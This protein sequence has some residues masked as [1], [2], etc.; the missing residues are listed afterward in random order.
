MKKLLSQTKKL[1]LLMS[2]FLVFS[3]NAGLAEEA[4]TLE[5]A[6]KGGSLSGEI[7]SYFEFTFAEASDS[8]YGWANAYLTLKYETL[9][10]NNLEFGARFFAHGELFSDHDDGTTD[11]F[12]T[13]IE[14]KFTLPELYLNYSFFDSS[15]VTIGRWKNVGHTEDKQSEGGYVR[16]KEIENVEIVAGIVKRLAD[17]DHDDSEDFGRTNDSQVLDSEDPFGAGSGPILMFLEGTYQPIDIV[18][19]NPYFM[20]HDDY[21]SVFGID[22]EINA[23]WE[24]YEVKYGGAIKY[25]NVNAEISGSTD[26]NIF[27]LQP[28][29]EKG[30]VKLEFSYSKFDDGDA[31]NQPAWMADPFSI[32]DQDETKGNPGAEVFESKIKYSWDKTW[33]SYSYATATYDTHATEGEG[34]HDHEFQ[35]GYDITESFDI[36]VQ[37]CIVSFD[38]I[39]NQDYNKIETLMRFKF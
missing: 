31:L 26:A 8:D 28:Y 16:F 17:V 15:N 13:D 32:V 25:V 14:T 1:I 30:P 10:W 5:E 18:T 6:F 29:I 22:T 7:G 12:D 34:Y 23:E 37:Y 21:A 19:F 33:V 35:I 9:S 38:D 3:I 2:V 11:P 4:D 20:Y 24:D 39:D 27:C 36:N